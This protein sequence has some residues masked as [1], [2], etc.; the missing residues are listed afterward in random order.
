MSY[1]FM[2]L[3]Y[4]YIYYNIISPQVVERVHMLLKNFM[5]EA[6]SVLGVLVQGLRSKLRGLACPSLAVSFFL[7]GF[8]WGGSTT[9]GSLWWVLLRLLTLCSSCLLAGLVQAHL[10][11]LWVPLKWSVLILLLYIH[12]YTC[13][14]VETTELG[15]SH[16]ICRHW[17]PDSKPRL[18]Q[19][20]SWDFN[21]VWW[22]SWLNHPPVSDLDKRP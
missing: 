1:S 14:Y 3:Q 21:P 15:W 18:K 11:L 7:L 10:V 9:S 6:S 8:L 12:A 2:Y 22:L 5:L 19:Y 17:C 4:G 13:V 16:H 20:K